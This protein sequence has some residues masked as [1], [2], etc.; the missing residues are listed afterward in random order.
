MAINPN[1]ITTVRVGELP[2]GA[3][4]LTSKIPHELEATLNQGTLSDLINFIAPFVSAVQFQVITL[5]VN[6]AYID[7]NFDL[8][9]LGINLMTGYAICNGNNGTLNKDGKVGIGYGS[10]YNVIGQTGGSKDAVVVSHHHHKN[11][12]P[13]KSF[14]AHSGSVASGGY[15]NNSSSSGGLD[16]GN[17]SEL[18]IGNLGVNYDV[19]GDALEQTIGVSGT[20]KNMQPYIVELHVMRL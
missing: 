12:S 13:F 11:G 15:G 3:F 10:T 18:A 20:D 5:H 9:G 16:A 2:A 6:Q 19:G 17:V 1:D 4:D 14:A 7:A 8:S